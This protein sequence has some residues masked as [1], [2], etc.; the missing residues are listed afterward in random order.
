[1]SVYGL[2]VKLLSVIEP[3]F[4]GTKVTR[5]SYSYP[6]GDTVIITLPVLLVRK[7]VPVPEISLMLSRRRLPS[8]TQLV[9]PHAH[10]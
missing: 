6:I 8:L 4:Q 5:L 7:S 10:E 9:T 1:M 3:N 2:D